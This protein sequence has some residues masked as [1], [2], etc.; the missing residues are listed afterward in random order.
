M[1]ACAILSLA[2]IELRRPVVGMRGDD[3]LK[4]AD[5][6]GEGL[7][8]IVALPGLERG[9]RLLFQTTRLPKSSPAHVEMP[10]CTSTLRVG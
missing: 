5:R 3:V 6:V 8:E 1:N 2:E 4:T 9:L 7:R 10:D